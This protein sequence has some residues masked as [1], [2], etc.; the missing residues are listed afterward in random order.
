MSRSFRPAIAVVVIVTALVLGGCGSDEPNDGAA[1]PPHS[2]TTQ[3]S[4]TSGSAD[5]ASGVTS[6][7]LRRSGGKAGETLTRTFDIEEPPPKG[8]VHSEVLA[9][10]NAAQHLVN[11][12][13]KVPPLPVNTCCDRYVFTV[14]IDFADGSTKTLSAVDGEPIPRAFEHLLTQLS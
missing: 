12:G 2:E 8:F 13:V 3:P 7:T 5:V 1:T 9:A 6:V 14:E 10:I 11:T 4:A